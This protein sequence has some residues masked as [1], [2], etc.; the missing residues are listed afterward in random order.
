MVFP[1]GMVAPSASL[2]KRAHYSATGQAVSLYTPV[3]KDYVAIQ[4]VFQNRCNYRC[5]YCEKNTYSSSVPTLDKKLVLD[6]L[7]NTLR[8]LEKDGKRLIV[9]FAGGEITLV[10]YL[11]EMCELLKKHDSI[12]TIITNGHRSVEWW[13][14]HA[15]FFDKV[16]MSYH[17]EFAVRER[18]VENVEILSG[19]GHLQLHLPIMMLPD[20]EVFQQTA[21]LAM[22]IKDKLIQQEKSFSLSAMPLR[23]RLSDPNSPYYEY[24]PEQWTFL[25]D[26]HGDNAAKPSA[27]VPRARLQR[28]F[29]NGEIDQFSPMTTWNNES[30]FGWQCFAGVENFCINDQGEIFRSWCG[31][32]PVGNIGN[33]GLPRNLAPVI[34]P[35]EACLCG[36]DLC[37]TKII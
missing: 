31:L 17:H 16:I 26:F 3:E 23:L 22:E 13:K 37:S 5:S 11:G 35:R 36:F 21:Q 18:Y 15:D 29:A 7:A 8:D 10:V 14:S 2:R 19:L 12:V 24:T 28:H 6:F 4:W 34:C 1:I 27:Y 20:V 25:N 33:G 9:E 30:F 32:P